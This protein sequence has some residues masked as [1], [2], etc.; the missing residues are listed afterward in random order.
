MAG[1]DKNLNEL[2]KWSIENSV[3]SDP[4]AP[5]PARPQTSLSPEA[6]AAIMGGPSDAELMQASVAHITSSDPEI[7]LESKLTAFDNLEQLVESLDNANLLSRLGLWTPLLELL[8]HE[9]DALRLMAAWCVGTAVQNNAPSQERLVALGGVERLV[10]MALGERLPRGDET[11]GE[12][13]ASS[14]ESQDVRRKAVYAL[15]SAVR[16]Y[17]PALDVAAKELRNRGEEVQEGIN[18]EDMDAINE[19]ING[20]KNKALNA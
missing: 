3:P 6:L 16:N 9:E 11:T 12:A 20:L 10:K 17:Q 1:M 8:G 4:S 15:S 13:V 7:T 19:L 18:A 2:L 14:E 5:A